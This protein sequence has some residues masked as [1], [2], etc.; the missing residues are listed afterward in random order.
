[1]IEAVAGCFLW[2]KLFKELGVVA[3]FIAITAL[4]AWAAGGEYADGRYDRRRLA[5]DSA[6]GKVVRGMVTIM[7]VLSWIVI[8]GFLLAILCALGYA[9]WQAHYIC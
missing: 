2:G 4:V 7:K 1:M 6:G 5:G 8:G 3:G 9:F